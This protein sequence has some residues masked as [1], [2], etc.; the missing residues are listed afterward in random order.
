MPDDQNKLAYSDAQD[1]SISPDGPIGTPALQG[2]LSD[3][4]TSTHILFSE[5]SVD[6]SEPAEWESGREICVSPQATCVPRVCL[7]SSAWVCGKILFAALRKDHPT[8]NCETSLA[9][10]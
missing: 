8:I 5:F 9:L 6:S 4:S 1:L 3:P 10:W 7:R 2:S